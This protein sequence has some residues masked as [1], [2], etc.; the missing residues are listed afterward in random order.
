MSAR[1]ASHDAGGGGSP[2]RRPR[3]DEQTQTRLGSPARIVRDQTGTGNRD[4]PGSAATSSPS[5]NSEAGS[6]SETSSGSPGSGIRGKPP[7]KASSRDSPGSDR[8]ANS[9]DSLDMG[10]AFIRRITGQAS[11]TGSSNPP[12]DFVLCIDGTG[13]DMINENEVK[14]TNVVKITDLINFGTHAGR[15]TIVAYQQGLGNRGTSTKQTNE[16]TFL[17]GWAETLNASFDRLW[18]SS[19][20]IAR[21]VAIN[22]AHI[23][24]SVCPNKDRIFLFGFSRGACVSQITAALV[25]DLGIISNY[26][27]TGKLSDVEHS[28]IVREIV[29]TWVLHKGSRSAEM[30]KAELGPYDKCLIPAKIHFLGLFDMVA[31]VGKPDLGNANLQSSTFR[32]AESVHD[33]SNILNAHHAVAISEHRNQFKPVLW[34][35]GTN[36]QHRSISQV[37]F[38]GFHTSI[39]GGTKTQG[40]MIYNVTLVWMLSKC[41]GPRQVISEQGLKDLI[42]KDASHASAMSGKKIPDSKKGIWAKTGMGD[43]IRSEM[44]SASIDTVHSTCG[45]KKWIMRCMPD[46]PDIVGTDEHPLRTE[47]MLE[48]NRIDRM[49]EFER[50]LCDLMF[51]VGP[52]Q[53]PGNVSAPNRAGRDMAFVLDS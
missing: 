39:G 1:G 26:L 22:Y 38:P 33:R 27:Y 9:A 24:M 5:R 43:H 16:K 36:E 46:I 37:W 48:K 10:E 30:I 42:R 11:Y 14:N 28:K 51:K 25:A 23:S 49:N 32:F 13:N 34:K 35:Q 15:M 40:I 45:K 4:S 19:S 53:P 6:Q 47:S 50:G 18:P 3:E 41:T 21:L 44:G 7:S 17:A 20:T 52:G 29:D 31:S 8:S 12:T 2:S